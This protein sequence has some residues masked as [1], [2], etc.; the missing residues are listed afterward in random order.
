MN[1]SFDPLRLVN[2]YGAFG[3]VNEE[4][5]QFIVSA[6]CDMEGPWRKYHFKSK[7][8]DVTRKPKCISPYHYRL[9]WQ[10]WIASSLGNI[11]RSP[12]IYTFLLKLLE[13]DPD[14]LGMSLMFVL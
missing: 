13:Q 9:D 8:G 1:S 10:F 6:A 14:V 2:T 4:R 7:P 5:K 3:T 12:W 11:N